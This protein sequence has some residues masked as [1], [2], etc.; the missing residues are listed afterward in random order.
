M[1]KFQNLKATDPDFLPTIK[2]LMAD[3]SEH[4]KEEE[5]DDLPSL[6]KALQSPETAKDSDDLATS[7]ERTKMFVPSRSHPSAGE[8]P[9]FESAMGLLVAPFDRVADMFRKFPKN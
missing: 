4:I 2:N 1:K 7:F 3:L 6:E 8:N 5:R 9:P